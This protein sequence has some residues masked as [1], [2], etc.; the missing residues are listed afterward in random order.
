M[1]EDGSTNLG[2]NEIT[3]WAAGWIHQLCFNFFHLPL[4]HDVRI[5]VVFSVEYLPWP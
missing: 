3:I 5:K 1:K 2:Y 4:Y